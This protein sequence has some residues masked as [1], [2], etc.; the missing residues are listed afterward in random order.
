[1]V[2]LR[3]L[4]CAGFRL[5]KQK[6]PLSHLYTIRWEAPFTSSPSKV[7]IEMEVLDSRASLDTPTRSP[8]PFVVRQ[9]HHKTGAFDKALLS[10]AEGLRPTGTLRAPLDQPNNRAYNVIHQH[11]GSLSPAEEVRDSRTGH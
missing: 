6:E 7:K 3:N 10:F 5:L 9:A 4:I 2:A 1:M 11:S 8:V